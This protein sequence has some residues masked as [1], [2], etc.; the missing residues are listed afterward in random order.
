MSRIQEAGNL[1]RGRIRVLVEVVREDGTL[2]ELQINASELT[3]EGDSYFNLVVPDDP[4]G[5]IRPIDE[6]GPSTTPEGFHLGI[7]GLFVPSEE[8][9]ALYAFRQAVDGR[10]AILRN[11]T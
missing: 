6:L 2:D 4:A 3:R 11:M 8:G 5:T 10:S 9:A 1:G 7:S